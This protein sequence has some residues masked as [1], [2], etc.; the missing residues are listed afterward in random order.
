MRI[1]KEHLK[2]FFAACLEEDLD[3][4]G[5][6]TSDAVLDSN[7]TTEGRFIAKEPGIIAGLEI[8]EALFGHVNPEIGFSAFTD[9]GSSISP[10]EIIASV[11][12][13][14]KDLLK[15]ERLS[16][17]ILQRLSG[18]ATRVDRYVRMVDGTG[19]VIMDTRKTTPGMRFLEKYAVRAGGGRNHRMGLFDQILVKD[20]H[21]GYLRGKGISLDVGL[22]KDKAGESVPVEIEA[23]SLEEVQNLT[24]GQPPDIIMLDNMSSDEMKQAVARIREKAPGTEIEASGG[25]TVE[26]VRAVA[27]TGVDRISVGEITHSAAAL[28]I[29]FYI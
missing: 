21:I 28:D 17:N 16:L 25:I 26:N 6:I 22:L 9:E 20:T 11:Q 27:E 8:L 4:A 29:G 2:R 12:G 13:P 18:I 7:D 15:C 3:R 19:A 1:D 5:D 23:R 14:V 24:A 10:D